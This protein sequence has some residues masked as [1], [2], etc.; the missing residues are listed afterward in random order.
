MPKEKKSL[1]RRSLAYAKEFSFYRADGNNLFCTNCGIS[2]NHNTRSQVLQHNSTQKHKLNSTS[3]SSSKVVQQILPFKETQSQYFK[4]LT[5]A[6]VKS[7]IPLNK[8][9]NSNFSNFL[10]QYTGKKSPDESTLRKNYVQQLYNE[11]IDFIKSKLGEKYVWMSIDETTDVEGRFVVNCIMGS[12]DIERY[13][14]LINTE[15]LPMVNYTTIARFVIDSIQKVSVSFDKVLVLVTD[16]ASYMIKAF[17]AIKIICPKS[18]HVLCVAHGLHRVC[19]KV[20]NK[21]EEANELIAMGKKV[22]E[23]SP[24][25]R[26]KLHAAGIPLP[27]S[28]IITRWGTWLQACQYYFDYFD[29]FSTVVNEIDGKGKNLNRLKSVLTSSNVKADIANIS[30]RYSSLPGLILEAES[31]TANSQ[32]I[33]EK[34]INM[35]LNFEDE[36]KVKLQSFFSKNTGFHSLMNPDCSERSAPELAALFYS[37]INSAEVERSFSAYK[38]LLSDLRRNFNEMSIKMHLCLQFN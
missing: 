32:N 5:E 2:V 38:L 7:N 9:N 6:L 28:P 3:C 20:R 13:I 31:R 33:Y 17:E 12:L 18:I 25:H 15:F 30:V 10:Q 14:F 16:S 36:I 35:S 27:P 37:P 34:A 1:S 4:D 11:K 24:H 22:F 29:T 21:F 19:E 8:I 23:K 26:Q